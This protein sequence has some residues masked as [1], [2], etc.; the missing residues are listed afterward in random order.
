MKKAQ[1]VLESDL[2]LLNRLVFVREVS[3]KEII[4]G[5]VK[6]P[7]TIAEL[8]TQW[9]YSGF[10]SYMTYGRSQYSLYQHYL[11]HTIMYELV[12]TVSGKVID[13]KGILTVT[14]RVFKTQSRRRWHSYGRIPGSKRGM[15]HSRPRGGVM[16][17]KKALCTFIE[18]EPPIRPMPTVNWGE[19]YHGDVERNWKSQRRHQCKARC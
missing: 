15:L 5:W 2:A 8:Y 10:Y 1:V 16:S 12:D 13:A 4:N 3:S 18:D 19:R 9:G 6:C 7:C 17:Y 11:L 14:D